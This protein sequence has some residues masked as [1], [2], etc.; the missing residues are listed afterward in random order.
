[1][2]PSSLCRLSSLGQCCAVW[3]G[4]ARAA[5]IG[6]APHRLSLRLFRWLDDEIFTGREGTLRWHLVR[7]LCWSTLTRTQP[8]KTC[9]GVDGDVEGFSIS[10]HGLQFRDDAQLRCGPL[11]VAILNRSFNFNFAKN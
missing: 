9:A 1:M 8:L 4:A 2:R 5:R 11:A 7:P 6:C 10:G 3:V